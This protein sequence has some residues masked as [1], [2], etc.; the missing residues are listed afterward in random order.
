MS[1]AEIMTIEAKNIVVGKLY[2]NVFLEVFLCLKK[3]TFGKMIIIT[4]M[5]LKPHYSLDQ[6]HLLED[7]CCYL[8]EINLE[9]I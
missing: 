1:Y 7:Y 9:E 3:E 8:N 6:S 2:E 5:G 4:W